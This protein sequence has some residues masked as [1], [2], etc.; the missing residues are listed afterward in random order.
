MKC[1]I[2]KLSI[3]MLLPLHT[4]LFAADATVVSP[5]TNAQKIMCPRVYINGTPLSSTE[6]TITPLIGHCHWIE[7]NGSIIATGIDSSAGPAYSTMCPAG[8]V[9]NQVQLNRTQSGWNVFFGFQVQCCTTELR[10]Q[11]TYEWVAA[12][13]CR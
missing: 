3:L 4:T 7:N 13:T 1:A 9:L 10:A 11:V 5:P 12:D 8:T 6:Q 2:M